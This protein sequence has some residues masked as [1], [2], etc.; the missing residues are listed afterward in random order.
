[1]KSKRHEGIAQ[2][3]LILGITA[4]LIET[5]KGEFDFTFSPP[6]KFQRAQT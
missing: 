2:Q 4:F 1:M 3:A 6:L 5:E